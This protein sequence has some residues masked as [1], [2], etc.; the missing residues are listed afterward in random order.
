MVGRRGPV[1]GAP[2]IDPELL[3]GNQSFKNSGVGINRFPP[4]CN[5]QVT[6]R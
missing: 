4:C 3:E 1:G 6:S 5:G 2:E